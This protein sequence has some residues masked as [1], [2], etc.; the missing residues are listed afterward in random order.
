MLKEAVI[1][2]FV[3]CCVLSI[4]LLAQ[5]FVP[6]IA[7]AYFLYVV[8]LLTAAS[9]SIYHIDK[10]RSKN[11]HRLVKR[12]VCLIGLS[13]ALSLAIV[14]LAWPYWFP[15]FVAFILPVFII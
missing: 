13:L 9:F 2:I 4:M 1:A 12:F 7:E 8:L 6:I 3:S 10:L 5:L 11:E 15:K 14:I